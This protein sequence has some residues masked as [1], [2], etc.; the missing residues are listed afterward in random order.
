[1]NRARF[2][3]AAL[4][5]GA[6]L[7]LVA[8]SGGSKEARDSSGGREAEEPKVVSVGPAEGATNVP[9]T[10]DFVVTLNQ[11]VENFED[12]ELKVKCRNCRR[13][14][15]KPEK[16]AMEIAGNT[17]R[18]TREAALPPGH[19]IRVKFFA[20]LKDSDAPITT[21][22]ESWIFTT[23]GTKA[24]RPS[25]NTSTPEPDTD[26]YRARVTAKRVKK[27]GE[28]IHWYG[29]DN[30]T[31]PPGDSFEEALSVLSPRYITN[32]K[33]IDGWGQALLI[34]WDDVHSIVVS[35]GADGVFER[36]YDPSDQLDYRGQVDDY[37]RD[38]VMQDASFFQ[39]PR[40]TK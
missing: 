4:V 3:A 34:A 32:P 13:G 5:I 27:I 26:E 24:D 25:R 8:C 40:G 31:L 22:N 20:R 33:T 35:A 29:V 16:E 6:G 12:M 2:G 37:N 15:V 14:V 19:E 39:H 1:M 30:A 11:D 28:A 10:T 21:L 36:D 9:V 7:A 23:A 38:V 18:F 17:L